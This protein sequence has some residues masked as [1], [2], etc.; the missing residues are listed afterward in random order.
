MTF[1][2][3]FAGFAAVLL[4]VTA[5]IAASTQAQAATVWMALA[6]N[7]NGNAMYTHNATSEASAKQSAIDACENRWAYDCGQATSVPMNWFL[8]VA[9]CVNSDG[10][11]YYTTGSSRSDYDSALTK[12]VSNA[13]DNSD[14]YFEDGD[15]T[16]T[17]QE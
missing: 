17:V 16:V 7:Q 15:C 4:L 12:A 11:E 8:V 14:Y 13:N 5:P 2:K 6:V 9:D 10:D 3:F 1:K